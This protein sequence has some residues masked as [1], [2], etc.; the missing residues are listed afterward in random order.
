VQGNMHTP[1]DTLRAAA[2][3]LIALTARFCGGRARLLSA[4]E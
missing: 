1:P 2:E 3:E 4:P